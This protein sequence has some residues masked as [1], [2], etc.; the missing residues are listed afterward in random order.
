MS[1]K[2]EDV[3]MKDTDLSVLSFHLLPLQELSEGNL[4]NASEHFQ[5][6][7][8]TKQV[9]HLPVFANLEHLLLH[10]QLLEK[11]FRLFETVMM[12][13]DVPIQFRCDHFFAPGHLHF[14]AHPEL[15]M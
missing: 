1:L 12:K 14:E 13:E 15:L 10:A 9:N 6:L 7:L 3:H 2:E 11:Q 5:L 8:D 4:K